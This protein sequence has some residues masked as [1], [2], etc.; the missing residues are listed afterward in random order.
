M[1]TRLERSRW[2]RKSRIQKAGLSKPMPTY[3]T[4]AHWVK[5]I[6]EW[7]A[8]DPKRRANRL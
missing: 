1:R 2:R 7:R 3:M 6:L 5:Y 8:E 4:A